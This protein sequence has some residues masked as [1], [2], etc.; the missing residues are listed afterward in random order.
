VTA[1]ANEGRGFLERAHEAHW[2]NDASS[3]LRAVS[4]ANTRLISIRQ[5]ARDWAGEVEQAV[6][7][8]PDQ[9]TLPGH[10]DAA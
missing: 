2:M 3:F 8:C 6:P 9:L 10:G 4:G 1:L 5:I 7:V